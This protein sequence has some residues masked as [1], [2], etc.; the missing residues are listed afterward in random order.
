MTRPT[1]HTMAEVAAAPETP[2]RLAVAADLRGLTVS[3]LRTE[4]R[5]GNL[6]IWRVSGPEIGHKKRPR[7]PEGQRGQV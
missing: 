2:I 4:A 5:R 7:H 6:T 1:L 3:G